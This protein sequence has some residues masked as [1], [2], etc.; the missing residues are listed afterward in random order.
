MPYEYRKLSAEERHKL[1][2]F[3]KQRG[4]PLHAPP[5]PF[6]EKGS[7]LI[8][9]ANYEH[10]PVMASPERRREFQN[11]L[12]DGFREIHADI[13]GWVVLPNHYH[14]LANVI[15]LDLVSAALKHVHGLTARE[16]NLQDGLTGKRRVWYRYSDRLVRNDFHLNHTLNYIHYN[17]IKHGYV[18]D[19]YDWPWS[20]LFMFEDENWSERLGESW[21]KYTPPADFDDDWD[22]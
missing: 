19:L 6:R 1:V 14:V 8:T 4:Y 13:I 18:K 17:P 22:P 16:W 9:A 3:R 5:H 10:A 20:S 11:I 2:E 12:L 21:K 7:Y 15:S